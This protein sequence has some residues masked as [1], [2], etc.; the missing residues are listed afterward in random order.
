MFDWQGVTTQLDRVAVG[1]LVEIEC[2][3]DGFFKVRA[4]PKPMKVQ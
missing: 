4:R 2:L 3:K 1:A